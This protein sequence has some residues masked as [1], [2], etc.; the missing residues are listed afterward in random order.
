MGLATVGTPGRMTAVLVD[1]QGH[2]ADVDLLD[3]LDRFG[4][5]Q[6]QVPAAAGAGVEEVVGGGGGEHLGREQ[7]ALVCGVSRLAAG[8]APLLAGWR[9]R[10]GGLDDVRGGGLGRVGGILE[11]RGELL[12][13]LLDDDLESHELRRKSS[14][15][16]CNRWQLAHGGIVSVCMVVESIRACDSDSTL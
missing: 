12:L 4:V 10:L 14:T 3:N 5:G 7:L 8:L 13:Q 1:L 2:V 6:V 11:G 9:L 15:S 16:A